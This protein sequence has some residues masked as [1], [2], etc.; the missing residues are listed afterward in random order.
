[1]QKRPRK[2]RKRRDSNY[3]GKVINEGYA[4]GLDK[5]RGVYIAD[6]S[7]DGWC[8]IFLGRAC[9]CKPEVRIREWGHGDD[10]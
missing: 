8:P 9:N 7:H 6:V 2:R 4:Q 10:A 1:M 3:M 5:K